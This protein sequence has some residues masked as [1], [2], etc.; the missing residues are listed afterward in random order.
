MS[1]PSSSWIPKSD[2]SLGMNAPFDKPNSR[3]WN[4]NSPSMK[5]N[6]SSGNATNKSNAMLVSA[7]NRRIGLWVNDITTDFN[8]LG[9]VAQS[10]DKQQFFPHN[11]AAPRITISGQCPNSYEFGR[12]GEVVREAHRYAIDDGDRGLD[13]KY[14]AVR[15]I[16]Y[17]LDYKPRNGT[18]GASSKSRTGK[19]NRTTKGVPSRIVLDGYVSGMQRGAERYEVAYNWQF[20]FVVLRA[21]NMLGLQDPVLN[22]SLIKVVKTIEDALSNASLAQPGVDPFVAYNDTALN[23]TSAFDQ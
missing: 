12:L 8:L 11:F 23:A 18:A 20:E 7:N 21:A 19:E 22:S 4:V 17:G 14:R 9:S 3:E 1:K 10:Q 2:P 15:F 16:K 5:P 6:D 13:D